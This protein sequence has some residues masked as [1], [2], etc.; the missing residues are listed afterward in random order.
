ML[1]RKRK[2]NKVILIASSRRYTG[3]L[4]KAHASLLRCGINP[5][6]ARRMVQEVAQ[7]GNHSGDSA[8][9]WA[10]VRG[11]VRDMRPTGDVLGWHWHVST[12]CGAQEP[13]TTAP[14]RPV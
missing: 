9:V 2:I 14:Q 8:D 5:E 7:T 4:P 13:S 11:T 6:L 10:F 1:K 3:P 12:R